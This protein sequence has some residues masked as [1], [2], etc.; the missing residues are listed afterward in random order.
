MTQSQTNVQVGLEVDTVKLRPVLKLTAKNHV[1]FVNNPVPTHVCKSII[2]FI[3]NRQSKGYWTYC[4]IKLFCRLLMC[5]D[6]LFIFGH[7]IS[8]FYRDIDTDNCPGWARAGYCETETSVQTNCRKSCQ[9]CSQEGIVLNSQMVR[10]M[11]IA[12]AF[13]SLYWLSF[14]FSFLSCKMLWNLNFDYTCWSQLN[15]ST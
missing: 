13:L 4:N 10:P 3:S 2:H 9:L 11:A 1:D 14:S 15:T 12:V 5:Q 6:S 8:L 7:G